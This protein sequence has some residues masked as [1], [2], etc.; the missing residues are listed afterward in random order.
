MCLQNPGF[1]VDLTVA[2]DLSTYYEVW[3]GRLD[4][5][6]AKR[7]GQIVLRGPRALQ[8][9]FPAWFTLSPLAPAVRQAHSQQRSSG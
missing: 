2:T 8:R 5:A 3:Y 9:S 7:D 6:R 1:E 4:L